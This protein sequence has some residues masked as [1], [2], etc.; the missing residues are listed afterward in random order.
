MRRLLLM[1]CLLLAAPWAQAA[2]QVAATTP[3]M[4]MLA[5][6]VGGEH[7]NVVV[8][9]PGDRDVH[10]LEARP[11][12]MV[13]L[14]RAD[15]LVA[16]GAELEVGWL[17]AAIQGAANP[18]LLPA[19]PGYFEAAGTVPLLDAG[20]PADR[21]LG[22]VHPEGNPHIYLDPLRMAT[23][24][25]A[26]AE[27]LAE[28]DA[29]NAAAYRARAQAFAERMAQ[30]TAAWQARVEGAPGA[31]LYHKDADYL[32]DRL[33]VPVLGYVEPLPGIPPTA[34]H[35]RQLVRDL[36]GREGLAFH[37][38]YEPARG[39]ERVAREL[40]WQAFRMQNNV[41]VD[42]TMEDYVALIE[43]WVTRLEGR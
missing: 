36:E 43:S 4:G 25:E 24:A 1:A 37:M 33:G 13:A 28:L 8:L 11:S 3:N 20:T 42:G 15:L 32:M 26:L 7:V 40:G 38:L 27:R 34:R 14:R 9:A 23:A 31:L 39:P 6:S 21:A 16:V 5:R 41:P 22:D 35:I 12:M 19:R 29:A 10:H 17:P 2:L 30:E 18:R